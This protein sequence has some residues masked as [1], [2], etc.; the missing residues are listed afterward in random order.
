MLHRSRR[1]GKDLTDEMRRTELT[2]V[3]LTRGS[4]TR[5]ELSTRRAAAETW[6]G[7]I[8]LQRRTVVHRCAACKRGVDEDVTYGLKVFSEL[9]FEWREMSY[10]V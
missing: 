9:Y 6:L 5:F 2:G 10:A 7:R 1:Y 4:E 8:N 3:S